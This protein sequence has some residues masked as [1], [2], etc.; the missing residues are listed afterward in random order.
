MPASGSEPAAQG[1]AGAGAGG[2]GL[3]AG[4][5]AGSMPVKRSSIPLACCGSRKYADRYDSRCRRLSVLTCACALTRKRSPSWIVPSGTSIVIGAASASCASWP[6]PGVTDGSNWK[7]ERFHS[8]RVAPACVYASK[9]HVPV[10]PK[11][12]TDPL[13][14]RTSFCVRKSKA[15]TSKKADAH[16][17]LRQSS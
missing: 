17:T 7:F 5:S 4:P 14:L 3:S 15:L 1:G 2:S 13:V 12:E 6:V 16:M 11:S 8:G 10:H 9:S